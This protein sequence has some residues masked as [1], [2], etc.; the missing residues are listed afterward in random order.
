MDLAKVESEYR[1]SAIVE[2]AKER[3]L[4]EKVLKFIESEAVLVD[5]PEEAKEPEADSRAE[6]P[7]Q[8]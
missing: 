3:K 6:G 2:R 1:D 5:T 4:Q 8:V 7:E